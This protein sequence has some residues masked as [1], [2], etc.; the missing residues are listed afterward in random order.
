MKHNQVM[1]TVSANDVC[2]GCGRC[3][4]QAFSI[5]W[6]ISQTPLLGHLSDT[7]YGTFIKH[8][9]WDIHQTPPTGHLKNTT[10]GHSTAPPMG[11][12]SNNN[13]MSTSNVE[14]GSPPCVEATLYPVST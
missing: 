9:P 14:L 4:Q 3:S 1:L 5:A 10:I 11:Y 8:P 12:L 6:A 7:T 13:V 2:I